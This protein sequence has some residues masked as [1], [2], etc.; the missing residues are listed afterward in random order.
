MPQN[1]WQAGS[2]TLPLL[3]QRL[4]CVTASTTHLASSCFIFHQNKSSFHN[5]VLLSAP[6]LCLQ[7]KPRVSTGSLLPH[8]LFSLFSFGP[9]CP[10]FSSPWAL[11]S[12]IHSL[13]APL[14]VLLQFL[15]QN[16]NQVNILQILLSLKCLYSQRLFFSFPV[17]GVLPVGQLTFSQLCHC[18]LESGVACALLHCLAGELWAV[19]SLALPCAWCDSPKELK[20]MVASPCTRK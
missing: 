17:S 20:A 15:T 3:A 4:E 16:W 5:D 13:L 19:C 11:M 9:L 12:D 1:H 2:H 6:P 18:P 8:N 10:L 14:W 7:A